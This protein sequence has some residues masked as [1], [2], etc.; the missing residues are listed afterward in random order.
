MTWLTENW[1]WVLFGGAFIAMH[2]FGHG[3]HGGHGKRKGSELLEKQPDDADAIKRPGP[4]DA[5]RH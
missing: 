2:V 5:D 3:C 4:I 1:L